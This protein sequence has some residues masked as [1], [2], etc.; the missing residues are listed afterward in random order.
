MKKTLFFMLFLAVSGIMNAQNVNIPDANF[1]NYLLSYNPKIDTNDDGE[2]QMSEALE[3]TSLSINPLPTTTFSTLQGIEAFTNLRTLRLE[4]MNNIA[5]DLSGLSNLTNLVLNGR[6]IGVNLT[7]LTSLVSIMI[8]GDPISSL[9]LSDLPNLNYV[10]LERLNVLTSLEL[11]VQTSLNSFHITSSSLTNIDLS[12]CSN[13]EILTIESRSFLDDVY[14]NLK[15]GNANYAFFDFYVNTIQPVTNKIYVCLDEDEAVNFR[16]LAE[17]VMISTYCDF[18]L[19]GNY[20]TITGTAF[21]DA[22]D[23][24]CDANDLPMSLMAVEIND[25]TTLGTSFTST[26]I[27]NFYT[28]AGTFTLTP[29]FENDWFTTAPATVTFADNNNNTVTQNF[30]VTAY[31]MHNDVEVIIVPSIAQPGFDAVYKI[32]YKNKG[33]Q[34]QSGNVSFTYDDTLLDYD[35]ATIAPSS[36][37]TGSLTWSYANLLPFEIREVSLTLN[38]N[39]P[40]EIPAV[41]INDIF[42]FTA[43]I[44]PTTGDETPTDNVFNL[45]QTV[46]G[47]YDPNDI[48]CIEGATVS[49]DKI[50]EYLH[51]NINF[52]NTGTAP[53]TFIAV[54]DVIDTTK[55]DIS[56][57]QVL[58]ASHP[59]EVRVTGNKVEFY[60]GD[61]NLGASEKGNVTFKIKTLETLTVNSNVTQQADIYFDYNWPI[62][63]N[64]AT[65]TFAIL[66][67]GSFA[68]DNSVTVSPNPTNGIVNISAKAEIKSV[69]LY[70]VQ[71]RLLQA[72]SGTTIDVSNR[73]AGLYFVKVMTA[74]G[75]K[76][77][78]LVRE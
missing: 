42:N 10:S 67:T 12:G 51:Y 73:A 52:E 9:D 23:N 25:G 28:Q 45:D 75:M 53:A 1:K 71:G 19:G 70:D 8:H 13:I 56:T 69:Q 34:T 27:Y 2:I 44:T 18:N 30:C 26:G 54:K 29:Q 35:S 61:I 57:L 3:V 46:I 65:T 39:G 50:G 48:T 33:N 63:T 14:I 11:G 38:A 78:K 68:K 55:Y 58:Y 32:I 21:F 6:I 15:N 77:E 47:S 37:S 43:A 76:V 40:M 36:T 24:G 5:V 62:V 4:I 59:M 20:N 31:G 74:K 64:E 41:N 60:F 49:P 22:N 16:E 7:G 17:N 72:A 66:S